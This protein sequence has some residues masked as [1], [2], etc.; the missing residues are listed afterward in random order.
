M[1]SRDS[2]AS[3]VEP[4]EIAA[5][6]YKLYSPSRVAIAS[7]LGSPLAAT[8]LLA[9]NFKRLGNQKA[10][11]LTWLFG[12]LGFGAYLAAAYAIYFWISENGYNLD[13]S[14]DPVIPRYI[15]TI[16]I[17]MFLAGIVGGLA[18]LLQKKIV[19]AHQHAGGKLDEG[20]VGV[21]LLWVGV[22]TA[23]YF[24]LPWAID[25]IENGLSEIVS[26]GDATIN[27]RY[28]GIDRQQAHAVG[29]ELLALVFV[30]R[31]GEAQ[32]FVKR[33][34]RDVVVTFVVPDGAWN[35]PGISN[36]F[37]EIIRKIA[38]FIG[39]LPAQARLVDKNLREKSVFTIDTYF[40]Q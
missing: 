28:K 35:T 14:A 3:T 36:T 6:I 5:P 17:S 33:S 18:S 23:A 1:E 15:T 9:R 22:L 39:G 25:R 13:K 29:K 4:I 8:H 31:N 7:F 12:V 10:T 27:V 37:R 26:E 20:G 16:F 11:W 32:V 34:R 40:D 21:V 2:S 24:K 38:P 19:R 30:A